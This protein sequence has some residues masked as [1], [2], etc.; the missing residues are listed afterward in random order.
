MDS[1]NRCHRRYT[2]RTLHGPAMLGPA[3]SP[4][5]HTPQV[6]APMLEPCKL[7]WV[8]YNDY[9]TGQELLGACLAS[10]E[11]ESPGA[12]TSCN[13]GLSG[14][15]EVGDSRVP[16]LIGVGCVDMN[17]V[18]DLPTL[19]S[20]AG[21]DDFWAKVQDDMKVCPLKTL[22]AGQMETLRAEAGGASARCYPAPPP[23]PPSTPPPPSPSLPP[24]PPPPPLLPTPPSTPPLL[25]PSTPP[26]T[27][28]PSEPIA[29]DAAAVE[30]GSIAG[31]IAG[32]VIVGLLAVIAYKF[33]DQIKAKVAELAGDGGPKL[34]GNAS[35]PS[36]AMGS[37]PAQQPSISTVQVEEKEEEKKEES[38][39][40]DEFDVQSIARRI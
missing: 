23:S 2:A 14:L 17:L 21:Y 16:K 36:V 30:A 38:K 9:Y 26:S 8:R 7:R 34:Y 28:P 40:G 27:P 13:G 29:A 33:R 10:F 4:G 5:T 20:H 18:V 35:K 6:L 24:L 25:P 22:T 32:V 15:G 19:E 1:C 39:E 3:H 31:P 37:M 12:Q 11:L